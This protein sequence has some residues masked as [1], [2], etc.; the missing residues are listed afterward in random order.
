MLRYRQRKN[1]FEIFFFLSGVSSLMMTL[2]SCNPLLKKDFPCI[3]YCK[4][5][6]NK[7]IFIYF[8]LLAISMSYEIRVTS[9]WSPG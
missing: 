4:K 1:Y 5:N 3:I 9:L 2:N 8:L 7:E 6:P